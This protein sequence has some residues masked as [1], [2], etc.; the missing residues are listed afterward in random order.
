ML[1]RYH[2]TKVSIICIL[3]LFV[4]TI[5]HFSNKNENYKFNA[6]EASFTTKQ[7]LH[8]A[9]NGVKIHFHPQVF[10]SVDKPITYASSPS[11]SSN[12]KPRKNIF[13]LKTHKTGSS[14]IQNILLRYGEK[15]NLTFALPKST[16]AHVYN[17]NVKFSKWM[18]R[19]TKSP[20]NILLNH[21]HFDFKGINEFMP[22]DTV[23]ITI[24]RDIESHFESVFE[25]Y[26]KD[27]NAFTR[28]KERFPSVDEFTLFQNFLANPHDFTDTTN[29]THYE[30]F[31]RNSMAFDFGIEDSIQRKHPISEGLKTIIAVTLSKFHLVMNM[32]HFDESL[33]LLKNLLCCSYE[34][35]IYL[36]MNSRATYRNYI[37]KKLS[38]KILAW[39]DLDAELYRQ[40]N[41]TFW[42]KVED[43]GAEK[44]KD[45]LAK[46]EAA[47]ARVTNLCVDGTE[48]GTSST[49]SRIIGYKLASEARDQEL[50]K[51]LV[52][53]E[54][55]YLYNIAHRQD[56]ELRS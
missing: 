9:Q 20:P 25:Y 56:L 48:I 4:L 47:R 31:S 23:Y 15:Y 35:L 32:D 22:S 42:E 10:Q 50:C 30:H 36:T 37:D 8:H 3:C 53:D 34:D 1:R 55:K 18:V 52:T 2:L 12:C 26:R 29:I 45:G 41:K 28:T 51:K 27:V 38:E 46:L 5:Q 40:A 54:R 19:E 13:F 43:F 21:L 7:K 33:V 24:V 11:A 14:T 17:Y 44:M 49:G 16:T 6:T 39:N